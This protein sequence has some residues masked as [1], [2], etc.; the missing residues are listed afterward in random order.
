MAAFAIGVAIGVVILGVVLI[1]TLL[2]PD[3]PPEPADVIAEDTAV[4]NS[5]FHPPG[6]TKGRFPV[7]GAAPAVFNRPL[8]VQALPDDGILP[9]P[10][11]VHGINGE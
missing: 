2:S 11:P 9:P 6:W 7:A 5:L 8:D 4:R 1:A 10:R 3:P